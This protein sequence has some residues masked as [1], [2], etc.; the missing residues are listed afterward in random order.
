VALL[1]EEET[2]RLA[3]GEADVAIDVAVAE[4]GGAGAG[5]GAK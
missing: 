1:F 4:D 5:E 3:V 2:K